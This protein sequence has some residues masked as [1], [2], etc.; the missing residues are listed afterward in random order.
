MIAY[1]KSWLKNM[2]IQEQADEALLKNCIS[3]NEKQ[4]IKS[5]NVVGFYTPN[6]F[7]RVGLALLTCIILL[8]IFGLFIL[9]SSSSSGDFV[10]GLAIFFSLV[11]YG[12]LEFVIQSKNHFRSGV[13]DALLWTALALFFGG[14]S[15][16]TDAGD[17]ANCMLVFLLSMYATLRFIDKLMTAV[18]LIALLGI[19]FF[20]FLKSGELFK[21]ILPFVL[22]TVS[23]VIYILLKKLK[24]REG[25]AL[26]KN[27]LQL[28]E[29]LALLCLYCAGNYFIVSELSN[30]LFHEDKPIALGWLFW[31]FTTVIPIIYLVSGIRKKDVVLIR[32][33]LLLIAAMVF[34]IKYYYSFASVEITML[35]AGVL[36]LLISYTIN[37]FLKKPAYGFTRDAAITVNTMGD[38]QIESLIL[39]Q[40]LTG[41]KVDT[42][43]GFGGGSFGGG[44][45]SGD[46]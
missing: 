13:D 3:E 16:L 19:F 33:G 5:V 22:M 46:F 20:I 11:I 40:T 38:L 17:I 45:S 32:S 10:G 24:Q 36:L 18:A 6:I 44:G 31:I 14:I 42:A 2:C 12:C 41:D 27:N 35:I 21:A 37:R 8:C 26:Y 39:A 9:L 30:E 29:I 15:F 23:L 43:P 34:T 7:I 28:V 25:L 1:N 4:A